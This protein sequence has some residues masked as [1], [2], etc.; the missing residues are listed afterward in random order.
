MKSGVLMLSPGGA[1]GGAGLLLVLG[2]DMCGDVVPGGGEVPRAA[3]ILASIRLDISSRS[4]YSSV[5]IE[6][7]ISSSQML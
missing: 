6:G 3:S 4:I 7:G 5:L 1:G 2:G